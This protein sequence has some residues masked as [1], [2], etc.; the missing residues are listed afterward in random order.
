MNEQQSETHEVQRPITD[1]RDEWKTYWKAQGMP[2]R[3]EPEIDEER[4][5]D[6]ARRRGSPP[7]ILSNEATGTYEPVSGDFEMDPLPLFSDMNPKLGRADVEWLLATLNGGKGPIDWASGATEESYA[8][9]RGLDLRGADLRNVNL[10]G[11]PLTYLR[12]GCT[13]VESYSGTPDQVE[14]AAAN[15]EGTNLNEAHLEGAFFGDAHLQHASFKKAHLEGA[16]FGNAHLESAHFGEAYLDGADFG[17]A[18]L[19][20]ADFMDARARNAGE[21]GCTEPI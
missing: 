8:W 17:V 3:T 11:L 20:D 9:L 16:Y 7:E 4:Q 21:L 19:Q 13:E 1:E 5:E 12:A 2:W 10:S 15:L 18:F 6:L 14:R